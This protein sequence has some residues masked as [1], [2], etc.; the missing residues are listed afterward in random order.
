MFCG[1]FRLVARAVGWF[2][3]LAALALVIRLE[4]VLES[5]PCRD[6][7]AAAPPDLLRSASPEFQPN[8]NP[9]IFLNPLTLAGGSLKLLHALKNLRM[10]VIVSNVS[11]TG[12]ASSSGSC[13]STRPCADGQNPGL[14]SG[15]PSVVQ[16]AVRTGPGTPPVRSCR[17]CFRGRGN[18][19]NLKTV[20][21][22]G[23]EPNSHAV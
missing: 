8:T 16:L 3:A 17:R 10:R 11:K 18:W 20:D 14:F 4:P 23:L 1:S 12:G 13:N 21:R 2:L 9:N 7:S 5:W 19:P 22:S 15:L 6:W